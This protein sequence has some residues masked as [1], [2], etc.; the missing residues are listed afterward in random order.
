MLWD[1]LPRGPWLLAGQDPR[2]TSKT[3]SLNSVVLLGRGWRGPASCSPEGPLAASS[4]WDS[5][6]IGLGEEEPVPCSKRGAK[7]HPPHLTS[8]ST[9]GPHY[10]HLSGSGCRAGLGN[11]CPLPCCGFWDEVG[12]TQSCSFPPVYSTSCSPCHPPL[13]AAFWIGFSLVAFGLRI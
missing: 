7:L 11:P 3:V 4:A 6:L 9:P 2:G 5:A 1:G 8:C 12:I 13:K 10:K